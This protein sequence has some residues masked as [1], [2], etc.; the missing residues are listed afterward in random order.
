MRSDTP[1]GKDPDA[2]S[3]TLKKYHKYLWSKKT[4]S[5]VTLNLTT[6]QAKVLIHSTSTEEFILSSD[7]FGHTYRNTKKMSHII[8]KVPISEIESFY[9]ICYTIGAFILFPA[10]RVNNKVTINAARGMNA[11]IGDRFDLTLECIRLYYLGLENPLK[12]TFD[13]YS[14]F[15]RLFKDFRGYVDFFLLQDLV[16]SNYKNINYWLPFKGF[17]NPPLPQNVD[18]YMLYKKNLTNYIK[19]RNNR[20]NTYS[21]NHLQP[22]LFSTLDK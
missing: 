7:A 14:N 13:R 21:I 3:P 5:G 12:T 9:S 4:K 11:K 22:L 17:D 8:S 16:D 19:Q 18:M 1:E 2:Y 15:F 10:K 6:R 20:I